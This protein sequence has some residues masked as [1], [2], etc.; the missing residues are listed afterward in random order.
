MLIRIGSLQYHQRHSK[1]KY[2]SKC[3]CLSA[4]ERFVMGYAFTLYPSRV[5][6]LHFGQTFT[7]SDSVCQFLY[8]LM[9]S[10]NPFERF[11]LLKRE[12][13]N[14]IQLQSQYNNIVVFCLLSD[15]PS[16]TNWS[17]S[18]H[19]MIPV[20]LKAYSHN[21]SLPISSDSRTSTLRPL[22]LGKKR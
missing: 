2:Q 14:W 20:K 19:S 3:F 4:S 12:T 18:W 13:V 11:N 9:R 5:V 8:G 10:F 16:I 15:V 17:V 6:N 22:F 7:E 21:S 1:P